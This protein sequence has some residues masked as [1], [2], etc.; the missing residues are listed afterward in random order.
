[1]Q[2]Q[3]QQPAAIERRHLNWRAHFQLRPLTRARQ[4]I[5]AGGALLPLVGR[6]PPAPPTTPPTTPFECSW[7]VPLSAQ[8]A[9]PGRRRRA[10]AANWAPGNLFDECCRSKWPLGRAV[11][12]SKILGK[13]SLQQPPP[14]L[15]LPTTTMRTQTFLSLSLSLLRL[16]RVAALWRPKDAPS[17]SPPP[18]RR[19]PFAAKWLHCEV[20]SVIPITARG[21][22]A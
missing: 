6:A 8:V 10:Q 3:Q 14:L 1:M 16:K 13:P 11:A 7:P 5:G 19:L 15:L 12:A 17:S 22:A 20:L 21:E 9:P 18:P 4:P 2:L